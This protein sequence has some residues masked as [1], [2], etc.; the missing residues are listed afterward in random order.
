LLLL[1]VGLNSLP[2]NLVDRWNYYLVSSLIK[3][4]CVIYSFVLTAYFL[5]LCVCMCMCVCV[6]AYVCIFLQLQLLQENTY[7]S[8]RQL[9]LIYIVNKYW[10]IKKDKFIYTSKYGDLDSV[11]FINN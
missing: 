11:N 1:S 6:C 7:R 2:L 4:I 3:L 10:L 5:C 9:E 8:W